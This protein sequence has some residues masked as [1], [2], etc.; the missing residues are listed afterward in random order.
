M[1]YHFEHK[2]IKPSRSFFLKKCQLR[3][4]VRA[5][6]LLFLSIGTLILSNL[7]LRR[8]LYLCA[9]NLTINSCNFSCLSSL[10]VPPRSS[11]ILK[12]HLSTLFLTI[13]QTLIANTFLP[14]SRILVLDLCWACCF[15]LREFVWLA[16]FCEKVLIILKIKLKMKLSANIFLQIQLTGNHLWKYDL[17]GLLICEKRIQEWTK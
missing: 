12:L 1:V 3:V 11:D 7:H 14:C 6:L 2:W 10:E 17:Y 8:N 9:L 5:G 13:N 16:Y 4:S 15:L